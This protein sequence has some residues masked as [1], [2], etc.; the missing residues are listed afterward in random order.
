MTRSEFMKLMLGAAVV[1]SSV[2]GRAPSPCTIGRGVPDAPK[3]ARAKR[4]VQLQLD[5]HLIG[6][7]VFCSTE[8]PVS[9][10]VTSLT[11]SLVLPFRSAFWINAE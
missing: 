1:P 7:C 9:Q 6:G 3:I 5:Y 4:E 10:T 11:S 2:V 8:Y